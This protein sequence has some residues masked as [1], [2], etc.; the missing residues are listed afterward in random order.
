[1]LALL[2]LSNFIVTL[3]FNIVYVALPEIGHEVGFTAHSLQW[4]VSAYVVVLGGFLLLGGRAADRLGQRRMLMLGLGLYGAASLAG[5]V[6]VGPQM[7]VAAR[8]VQGLGGALL[9]P[10]T[11][12]MIFTSFTTERERNGALAIWGATGGA[13]LS[14]GALL[15]GAITN[16]LGWSWVFFINVPLTVVGL[17]AALR[18]AAVDE[19]HPAGLS[20]FDLPGALIATVGSSL[21]VF[22]L[23]SGPDA[24]WGSVQGAGAL[25]AG[26]VLLGVFVLVEARTGSPLVPLRLFR[27]RNL[28][29]AMALAFIFQGAAAAGMY[30]LVTTYLQDALHYNPLDAGLAFLPP[31]LMATA[32]SLRLTPLLLRRWGIR[33]TLFTGLTVAGVG[34]A[35]LVAVFSVSSSYWVLLPGLAVWGLGQG[36]S[37]PSLF[38]AAGSEVLPQEQGVAS[39]MANMARQI[40]GA[41]GLAALVAVA[42]AGLRAG[43]GTAVPRLVDGLRLA[44]WVAVI[45]LFIGAITAFMIRKPTAKA[46]PNAPLQKQAANRTADLAEE[47]LGS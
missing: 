36:L 14:A 10:A 29:A 11:L 2:A 5:G 6:A 47:S 19:R 35:G 23:S 1:L 12:R 16:Y 25:A 31:T 45:V 37:F 22:G 4:V 15:G 34:T 42:S 28:S 20:G 26:V 41:V 33:L 30:Y 3:D 21:V 18:V 27:V 17:I 40:G 32:A 44:G 24:G 43:G 9:M 39:S 38:A 46:T 7:L 13:G 8:A